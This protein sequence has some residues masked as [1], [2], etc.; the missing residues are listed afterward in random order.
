MSERDKSI[1]PFWK[2]EN[3]FEVCIGAEI[4]F[5]T[6]LTHLSFVHQKSMYCWKN[7]LIEMLFSY[8]F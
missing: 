1:L 2:K 7:R 3:L 6:V 4:L 5:L 8:C